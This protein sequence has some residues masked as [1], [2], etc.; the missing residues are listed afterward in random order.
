MTPLT[1]AKLILAAAG[2][3]IWGIGMR[4]GPEILAWIG[5]ALLTSAVLLRFVG[6][7]KPEP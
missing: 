5:I 2:L 6:R 1:T 7:K 3:M 4:S